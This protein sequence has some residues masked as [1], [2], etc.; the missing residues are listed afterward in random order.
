MLSWQAV[1]LR[2]GRVVADLPDLTVG[3][4]SQVIGAYTSTTAT[5]PVPTAPEGWERATLPG[6]VALVLTDDAQDGTAPVPLWGGMVSRRV[7]DL[8]D[9]VALSLSTLE[10]YFDRRFVGDVTFTATGQHTIVSGV[11]EG[12]VNDGTIDFRVAVTAAGVARDRTY[13]DAEDKTVYSVL[14]ELMGVDGGPEW[15]VTWEHQSNP[16]R[17]TPVLTSADRIGVSPIAGLAPAATF[18][19]PGSVLEAS[20]VEDYASGKGANDVMAASTATADVRPQSPRQ[21]A[22]DTDRPTFEHRF[23]PSTSITDVATLTSHALAALAGMTS[24]ARSLSLTAVWDDAPRLGVD[25][26]IGDDIAYRIGG[27][28]ADPTL[29]AIRDA[30]IDTYT[31]VYGADGW[32]LLHP[33]GLPTVPAFPSGLAGIARAIGWELSLSEPQTITPVLVIDEGA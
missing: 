21:T 10:A 31:D 15:T 8:G 29:I 2:D 28:V 24:G 32:T 23:T 20:F 9:T 7:R 22:G 3:T 5:L 33:N 6:A 18:E 30:Y 17:F 11:V 1:N 12:F 19:A 13:L 4:V 27:T 14:S 25:W 26:S 16:E